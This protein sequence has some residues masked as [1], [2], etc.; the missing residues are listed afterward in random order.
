MLF[1]IGLKVHLAR[2]K[3]RNFSRN[4]PETT[5]LNHQ[6]AIRRVFICAA[7]D[8]GSGPRPGTIDSAEAAGR[9]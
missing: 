8:T 5:N 2:R 9:M 4:R 7:L 1:R 6:Y 3:F